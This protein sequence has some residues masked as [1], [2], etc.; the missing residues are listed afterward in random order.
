MGEMNLTELEREQLVAAT[1]SRTIRAADARRAKLILM[2][3]DFESRDAIIERLGVR[4]AF[5]L[6]LVE[7]VSGRAAGGLVRAPPW[8]ST[9]AAA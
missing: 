8:T 1:R 9:T 7:S 6:A 3:E 5:H 2:L 4:L